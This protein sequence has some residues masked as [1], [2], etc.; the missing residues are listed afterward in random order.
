MIPARPSV[1]VIGGGTIGLGWAVALT[2][3]GHEVR[4]VEPD[5]ARRATLREALRQRVTMLVEHELS[6]LTPDEAASRLMLADSHAAALDRAVLAL[7]C[8]PEDLELKRRL[9][10]ELDALAPPDMVIA[11]CSSALTVSAI[12]DQLPGRARCLVAHPGNPPFLLRVVEIVPAPFTAEPAVGQ[13][14]AILGG[15]G[16]IPVRLNREIEGFVFNRLQGA[17]LR[18]AY[19]LVHDGV[20]SVEAIDAVM[21]EGLGPRWAI[22]GPFETAD[23]NVRGGIEAHAARMGAAYARMGKERGEVEPWSAE[24]V[25]AVSAQRRA[26]LPLEAWPERVEWRDRLLAALQ[27]TRRALGLGRGR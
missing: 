24:L 5:A 23:L 12:A 26:I 20:A 13:A 19:A 10:A 18:E 1:A 9:F 2:I 11:T 21:R 8:A 15:A 27:H 16:M 14:I 3:A 22:T 6:A 17:V 25:A 7:E 4:L